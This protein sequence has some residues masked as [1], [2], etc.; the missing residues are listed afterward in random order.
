MCD[1][2]SGCMRANGSEQL[3]QSGLGARRHVRRMADDYCLH[4]TVV[5]VLDQA[6]RAPL[7]AKVVE[8]ACGPRVDEQLKESLRQRCA[9]G[10]RRMRRGSSCFATACCACSRAKS[11]HECSRRKRSGWKAATSHHIVPALAKKGARR[12]ARRAGS[13][14][15]RG[16]RGARHLVVVGRA[17]GSPVA[18]SGRRPRHRTTRT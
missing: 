15:R 4:K 2:D 3:V 18:L 11:I 5:Q 1:A 10:R 13:G 8:M 6:R 12:V 9:A 7:V 14:R 16:G 17:V